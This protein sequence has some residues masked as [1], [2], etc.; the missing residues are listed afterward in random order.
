[1]NRRTPHLLQQQPLRCVDRQQQQMS[2]G[3]F[4]DRGQGRA[5]QMGES[6]H[7]D[8]TGQEGRFPVSK[9]FGE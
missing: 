9:D 7:G 1:M 5:Q 2:G 4:Q 8:S 3:E 6:A